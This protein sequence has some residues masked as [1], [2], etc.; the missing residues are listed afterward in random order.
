MATLKR[1]LESRRK[2]EEE[3]ELDWAALAE[4]EGK[5]HAPQDD[6]SN[7][8]VSYADMM[9]LLCGF[10]IMMFSMA[11]L[12][13][14]TYEKVKESVA[15]SFG[16]DYKSPTR[17]LARFVTQTLEEAGLEREAA[18]RVDPS[19]IS[20]IFRSA[21][22]FE[23]SSSEVTDDGRKILQKL[24][25]SIRERQ[26]QELKSYRVVVEGHTD[27]KPVIGGLFPSNW[28]LSGARAARVIR[29]FLEN[30]FEASRLTAIGYGE[31][32]PEKAERD[33]QGSWIEENLALNRRVVIRILEPKVDSIPLPE[34][35]REPAAAPPPVGASK[36]T[37]SR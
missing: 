17:E 31:T 34:T 26:E 25:Q 11:K 19:G 10:F 23:S 7:W 22:F 16:G 35:A 18:I 33:D 32:R 9:T 15:K 6:E 13:E 2:R 1:L 12:D 3:Q 21:V 30:G 28:E 20:L 14:P 29:L 4:R 37:P 5:S 8:L 24:I 36:T 27:G